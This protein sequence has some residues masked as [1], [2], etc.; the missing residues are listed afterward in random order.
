MKATWRLRR[1][2]E[3]GTFALGARLGFGGR[4]AA[5]ILAPSPMRA[6]TH[7]SEPPPTSLVGVPLTDRRN[8]ADLGMKEVR[9]M[10]SVFEIVEW[11]SQFMSPVAFVFCVIDSFGTDRRLATPAQVALVLIC[12][13]PVQ[14]GVL[15]HM[16]S[17][18]ISRGWPERGWVT[19]WTSKNRALYTAGKLRIRKRFYR[20]RM[21]TLVVTPLSHPAWQD[22]RCKRTVIMR[23]V[24]NGLMYISPQTGWRG[25]RIPERPDRREASVST[26]LRSVDI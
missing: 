5:V 24:V 16:K 11:R 13:C 23:E 18:V 14:K 17:P 22:G 3:S 10:I 26:L 9:A 6:L 4:T 7:P 25:A 1:A 20:R 12:P 15:N 21:G 19:D 8:S 2:V